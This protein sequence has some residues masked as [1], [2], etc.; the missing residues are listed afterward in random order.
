M[1]CYSNLRKSENAV[2][3]IRSCDRVLTRFSKAISLMTFSLLS[4]A[5]SDVDAGSSEND[6]FPEN[7]VPGNPEEI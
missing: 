7:Q 1:S 5:T 2:R 3:G 6:G 4:V